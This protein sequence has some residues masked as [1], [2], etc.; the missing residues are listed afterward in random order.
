MRRLSSLTSFSGKL[1]ESRPYRR[2]R[3]TPILTSFK[4]TLQVVK[5]RWCILTTWRT[6]LWRSW[7][8]RLFKIVDRCSW[9]ILRRAMK[10]ASSMSRWKRTYP[11]K[12]I[13]WVHLAIQTLWAT[14]I[15][16][17]ISKIKPRHIKMSRCTSRTGQLKVHSRNLTIQQPCCC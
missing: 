6:S 16:T 8:I 3:T 13:L 17:V 11:S 2:H 5:V 4:L 9:T 15:S 10:L 1:T 12:L 14:G 7:T